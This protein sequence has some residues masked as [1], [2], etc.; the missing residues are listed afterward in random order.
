VLS[1]DL[2]VPLLLALFRCSSS[3][4][5]GDKEIRRKVRDEFEIDIVS[6]IKGNT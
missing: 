5:A 6:E 3:R 4:A 2:S 1:S